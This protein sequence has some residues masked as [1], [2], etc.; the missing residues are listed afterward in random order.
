MHTVKHFYLTLGLLFFSS[1]LYK[2][3][4]HSYKCPPLF[5]KSTPFTVSLVCVSTTGTSFLSGNLG[6]TRCGYSL[7]RTWWEPETNPD[8]LFTQIS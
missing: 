2:L 6:E 4:S 1:S 7:A 3:D 5:R 8:K